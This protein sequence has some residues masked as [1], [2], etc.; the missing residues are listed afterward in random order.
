[1]IVS[2]GD[3][4][5]RIWSTEFS[6]RR[7]VVVGLGAGRLKR[8]VLYCTIVLAVGAFWKCSLVCKGFFIFQQTQTDH[9]EQ[10]RPKLSVCVKLKDDLSILAINDSLVWPLPSVSEWKMNC[11]VAL[12]F[13]LH[14][15]SR[16]HSWGWRW[17]WLSRSCHFFF[18]LEGFTLE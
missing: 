8:N 5:K 15:S 9:N 13:G 4:G 11:L 16:S 17:G 14:S 2:D 18:I 1:M 6:G 7:E 12:W 10:A 3:L